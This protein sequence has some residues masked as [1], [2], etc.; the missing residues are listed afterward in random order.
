MKLDYKKLEF[1]KIK[2]IIRFINYKLIFSK[3][4]NIYLIFYIFLLK[5][6]PPGVSLIL[7]TKI[8]LVN[9]N[10]EY[11]VENILNYKKIRGYIKYLIK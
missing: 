4:M 2:K 1:F 7:V 3:I 9:P 5:P 10:A 8:E 11:K 6:I